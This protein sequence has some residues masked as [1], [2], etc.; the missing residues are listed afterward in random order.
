MDKIMT[1][2][3][4]NE[5]VTEEFMFEIIDDELMQKAKEFATKLARHYWPEVREVEVQQSKTLN[6][7]F[8][9]YLSFNNE[10]DKIVW[11]LKHGGH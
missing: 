8:E 7:D 10:Q 4:L 5:L 1:I 3:R 9:L 11:I 2:Q 6:Y